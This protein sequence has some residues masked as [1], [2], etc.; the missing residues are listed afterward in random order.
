MSN[1]AW[2]VSPNLN[3]SFDNGSV[4]SWWENVSPRRSTISEK[5]NEIKAWY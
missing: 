2:E 1:I 5:E 3:R 4:V